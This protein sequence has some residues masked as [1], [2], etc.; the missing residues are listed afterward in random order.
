MLLSFLMFLMF[1]CV[2]C[3]FSM[4]R[5]WAGYEEEGNNG[6]KRDGNTIR[7]HSDAKYRSVLDLT[8]DLYTSQ[9]RP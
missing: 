6:E 4:D 9:I 5:G 8:L 2:T 1:L 3:G 7:R